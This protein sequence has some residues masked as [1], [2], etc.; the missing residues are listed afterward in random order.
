VNTRANTFRMK[1]LTCS[2]HALLANGNLF[3]ASGADGTVDLSIYKT[4][5]LFGAVSIDGIAESVTYNPTLNTWTLNPKAIVKG[6]QGE[7]LRWYATVT[8]L[9]DSRMLLTGGYEAVLPVSIYNRSVEAFDPVRNAWTAVSGLAQTPPGIENPDYTHVWQW[10][11]ADPTRSVMMIGGSAE[12]LFMLMNRGVT[13]W[14]HTNT[15]RPGAKEVIDA[16][17]PQPVFPNH[18]SSSAMLPLRL[19]GDGWGYGNGSILYA[20]GE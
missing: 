3:F 17:A 15:Y 4:G 11:Y 1:T 16:F 2:G 18:G 8:R 7:P 14:Q 5:D 20:G 12:P 9:A 19:P 13:T 6:P 10:P